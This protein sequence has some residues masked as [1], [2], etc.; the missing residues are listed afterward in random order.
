MRLTAPLLK[1][2]R[3]HVPGR[4]KVQTGYAAGCCIHAVRS[5]R[6]LGVPSTKDHWTH[7]LFRP[8]GKTIIIPV[9]KK[10]CC[11][12]NN[13]YRPVALTSVVMKCFEKII[14][15][16]LKAA[17]GCSLDDFQF[18]YRSDRGIEDAVLALDYF[19]LK[20][21]D[22]NKAYARLLLVD[23]SSAFYT[24]QPHLLIKGLRDLNVHPFI[25]R[26]YYSFLTERTQR[27]NGTM[28]ESRTMSTGVPQGCVSSPVL[29]ILYT[30]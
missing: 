10:P 18:A 7:V 19:L 6:R 26:W 11:K 16:L 5:L 9:P 20:H 29:F 17:V 24:L 2:F 13:D 25:I 28:S 8:P 12:E 27:V 21:L 30:N 23:F 3:T 22:N 1:C 15:S 14:I 4:L